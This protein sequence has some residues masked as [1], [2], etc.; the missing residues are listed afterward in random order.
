MVN[1]LRGCSAVLKGRHTK[2]EEKTNRC[3]LYV[4]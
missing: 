1:Q 3:G 4:I 2:K